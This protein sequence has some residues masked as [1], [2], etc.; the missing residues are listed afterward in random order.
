[1][2]SN[3]IDFIFEKYPLIFCLV[4]G[5]FLTWIF[6]SFYFKRFCPL[7]TGLKDI[8][9][10]FKGLK[11][12]LINTVKTTIKEYLVDSGLAE[13]PHHSPIS[14]TE[15]DKNIIESAGFDKYVKDNKKLFLDYFQ[16]E[17]PQNRAEGLKRAVTLLMVMDEE[18]IID[19]NKLKDIGYQKGKTETN[20]Q[21]IAGIYLWQNLIEPELYRKASQ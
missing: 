14:L 6:A 19:L 9:D 7:E 21:I 18:K 20:V 15:E 17:K 8:Q 3:V 10:G 5:G 13:F 16:S 12:S 2:W 1:M 11:D 4:L